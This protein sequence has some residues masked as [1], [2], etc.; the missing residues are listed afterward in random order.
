MKPW[1]V[2]ATVDKIRGMAGE[3]TVK[4]GIDLTSTSLSILIDSIRNKRPEIEEK[5][6]LWELKRII[7]EDKG[8]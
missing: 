5:E 8:G 2:E 4:M 7:W 3:E 1:E 6:L